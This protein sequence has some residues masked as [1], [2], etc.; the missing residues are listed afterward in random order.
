MKKRKT[1]K[2]FFTNHYGLHDLQSKNLKNL[3]THLNDIILT[4]GKY[5]EKFE[6]KISKQVN[7]KY[8][9]V[10]NNGTSALMLGLLS[11]LGNNKIYA[12]VPNI[13]FVAIANI[14][15]LLRGKIILC[16]VNKDTGMVDD[17]TFLEI[18]KEC[19]KKNIKPNVLYQFIMLEKF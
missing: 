17:E 3:T 9:V 6:K 1:N 7:S 14:I 2:K 19:K 11:L 12:I 5:C 10:C 16:D 8:S 13:N 4:N 18:L 15:K